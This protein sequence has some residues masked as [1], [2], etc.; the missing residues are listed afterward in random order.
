M[1]A[2]EQVLTFTCGPD[3][4]LGILST[5][6]QKSASVGVVIVVGGP[7]YRAGSHRL[8]T[9]LARELAAAGYPVLRFDYRG[10]G[11]SEGEARSFEH[12]G[13]D[14]ASAIQALQAHAAAVRRVVLWGLCDGASAAL[15]YAQA[16]GDARLAG[17]CLA[18]PWVRST[19]SLAKAHVK[20]YYVQ[21]LRQKDFWLK[22]LS[23]KV[24]LRAS[25][26]LARDIGQAARLA[27]PAPAD[28]QTF[29][30][31]MLAGWLAFKGHTLVVL[32]GDDITA[33]E[34]IQLTRDDA[35]WARAMASSPVSR[36]EIALADHTFSSANAHRQLV[37]C[38]LTWLRGLDV[39]AAPV[40][41]DAS[42][43]SKSEAYP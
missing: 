18:N 24:A 15:L 40:T 7:Q 31:R 21:R 28:A 35:A 16:T 8:F 34:F 22:L 13:D 33:R 9:L 38:T 41:P 20:H 26:D 12:V 27:Q 30:Q 43:A 32:S 25:L 1:N 29:Q 19:Q 14:I 2:T 39:L 42:R 5:P 17:L 11:D 37:D 36:H 6:A 23:G 4:L 10:M 3:R